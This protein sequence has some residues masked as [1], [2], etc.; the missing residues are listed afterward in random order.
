MKLLS[1]GSVLLCSMD[2]CSEL[3][4]IESNIIKYAVEQKSY[5]LQGLFNFNIWPTASD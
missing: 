1:L 2:E 3:L 5:F 4:L